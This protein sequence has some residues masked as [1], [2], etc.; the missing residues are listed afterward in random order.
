MIRRFDIRKVNDKW[1]IAGLTKKTDLNNW[2][3]GIDEAHNLLLV[4]STSKAKDSLFK[5]TSYPLEEGTLWLHN[6]SDSFFSRF[7]PKAIQ[8]I[9]DQYD[10]LT[11]TPIKQKRRFQIPIYLINGRVANPVT[12]YKDV[13]F[14][15]K[16]IYVEGKTKRHDHMV[17]SW[18]NV[19]CTG[20]CSYLIQTARRGKYLYLAEESRIEEFNTLKQT[21]T[22][23]PDFDEVF[24][25]LK[26]ET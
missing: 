23:M 8:D 5:N 17:V 24:N 18:V 10:I 4:G 14:L 6:T 7:K 26:E 19:E 22:A 15:S 11:I 25:N 16:K 9:L 1:H 12:E 13:V 3:L 2:S 21:G 20:P